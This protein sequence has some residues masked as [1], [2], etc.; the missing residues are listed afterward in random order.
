[1]TQNEY[2]RKGPRRA[3][4]PTLTALAIAFVGLLAEGSG[5]AQG[6]NPN[7]AEVRRL[8]REVERYGRSARESGRALPPMLRIEQL[9]DR[10]SPGVVK[11]SLGRLSASRRL[12]PHLRSY[13]TML[14]GIVEQATGELAVSR[15]TF[16]SLGYVK[17]W[18]VVGAFDNEGKLGLAREFPPETARNDAANRETTYR[19]KEREVRWRR[20][21]A[22]LAPT[23]YISFDAV[24]RP[25]INVCAYAETFVKLDRA[26]PLTLWLGANGAANA[27][28]YVSSDTRSGCAVG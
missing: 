27:S 16:D 9:L 14:R 18:M 15:A 12:L 26:Q 17:D 24:F 1:M 28:P 10:A 2:A 20:F 8:E 22:E 5:E 25:W 6:S 3:M 23:G 19:G 13:A 21:P 11:A 7:D 4:G